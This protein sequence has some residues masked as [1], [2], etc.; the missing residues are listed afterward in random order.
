MPFSYKLLQAFIK[1]SYLFHTHSAR[2]F[3]IYPTDIDCMCFFAR[4]TAQNGPL[5]LLFRHASAGDRLTTFHYNFNPHR[6]SPHGRPGSSLHSGPVS[7]RRST[8]GY[9]PTG[10]P[11]RLWCPPRKAISPAV[12]ILSSTPRKSQK[13]ARPAGAA[14]K[15]Y[16]PHPCTRRTYRHICV[17][18]R[19]P[20]IGCANGGL[21]QGFTLS[22]MSIR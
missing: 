9:K 21:G 15:V 8:K 7:V 11:G 18:C 6:P 2:I 3:S 20:L 19:A 16:S 5:A 22:L 12:H 14:T 1:S 13:N 17:H 4:G 10:R